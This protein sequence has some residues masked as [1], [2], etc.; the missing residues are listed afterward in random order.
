MRG[1]RSRA[2]R[3][4][5]SNLDLLLR[6]AGDLR[7]EYGDIVEIAEDV[8][9]ASGMGGTSGSTGTHS[10]P[11]S[12]EALDGR[13]AARRHALKEIRKAVAAGLDALQRA[14]YHARRAQSDSPNLWS[15]RD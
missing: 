11:T 10:D 15:G 1:R 13:R 8:S 6:L 5:I 4:T 9:I 3:A 14:A 2:D 12:R 7:R